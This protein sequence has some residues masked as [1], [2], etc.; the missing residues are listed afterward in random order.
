MQTEA[1]VLSELNQPLGL[2]TLS[3]PEPA[4]GQV[5]VQINHSGVCRTQIMEDLDAGEVGRALID[6]SLPAGEASE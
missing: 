4:P 6:M 5:L 2:R 1:A 3:V